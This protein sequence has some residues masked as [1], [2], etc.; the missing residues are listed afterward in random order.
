MWVDF[1]SDSSV[2]EAG[3]QATIRA[4]SGDGETDGA[5]D[6]PSEE[7]SE[8]ASEEASEDVCEPDY[9]ATAAQQEITSPEYPSEYPNNHD[10]CVSVIWAGEGQNVEL[11]FTDFELESHSTCAYDWVQVRDGD[12]ASSELLGTWCGSDSPGTIRSSGSQLYVEF[13]SDG[14]V[15]RTGYQAWFS[16]VEDVVMCARPTIENGDVSPYNDSIAAG[17][18][19]TASCTAGFELS[20]EATMF[21]DGNGTLSEVPRCDEIQLCWNEIRKQKLD[22]TKIATLYDVELAQNVCLYMEECDCVNCY[23]DASDD[24]GCRLYSGETSAG[25]S[26]KWTT[27]EHGPC[28]E[29]V[30]FGR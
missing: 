29:A 16:A 4:F 27:Y 22:G 8:E 15:V 28:V 5:T 14:S 6:E 11:V 9:A 30:E 24:K 12:S 3:F 26:N 21:C 7:P 20:G 18:V 17:S 13:H 19:Y 10:D 2:T 1:H 23:R 25:S